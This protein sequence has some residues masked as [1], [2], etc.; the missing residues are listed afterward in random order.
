MVVLGVRQHDSAR[1]LGYPVP[2]SGVNAERD[3]WICPG[4]ELSMPGQPSNEVA[5]QNP[6][7]SNISELIGHG[8]KA[9]AVPT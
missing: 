8:I 2:G 7:R 3:C 4:G 1:V 5:S 6:D 9:I